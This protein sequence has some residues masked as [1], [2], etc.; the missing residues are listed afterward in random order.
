MQKSHDEKNANRVAPGLQV[1]GVSR[2]ADEKVDRDKETQEVA[3]LHDE[4]VGRYPG[5]RAGSDLRMM[6][7]L[8]GE[9]GRREE[10]HW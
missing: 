5:G 4:E 1:E 7:R 8:V 6:A 2:S 10:K 9:S 3:D